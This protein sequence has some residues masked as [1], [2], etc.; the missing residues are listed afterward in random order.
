MAHRPPLQ[1]GPLALDD[2]EARLAFHEPLDAVAETLH[3]GTRAA[4]ERKGENARADSVLQTNL[5]C[6]D[7]NLAPDPG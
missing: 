2:D 4:K 3:L 6:A 5:R 7:L 1:P